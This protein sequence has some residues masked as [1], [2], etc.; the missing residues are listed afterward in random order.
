MQLKKLKW[1]LLV[2]GVLY[3]SV[4]LAVFIMRSAPT[5]PL[6][7]G[8][9]GTV[10][11]AGSFNMRQRARHTLSFVPFLTGAVCEIGPGRGIL[12]AE[13]Q[14]AGFHYWAIDMDK[15]ALAGITADRKFLCRIPPMPDLPEYPVAI[16]IESV[17]EHMKDS[18]EVSEVLFGCYE[19]LIDGG[20]VVVRVPEIRYVKWEFWDAATDHSYVT[21]KRRMATLI[22]ASGFSIIEQGYYLDQFTGPA[23]HAVY[24]IKNLWPWGLLHNLFYE[25]WQ[26]S[27]FSK[28]AEKAPAVYVVAMKGKQ[29]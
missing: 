20:V 5:D 25:P 13:A 1:S 12:A 15:A 27:S 22:R 7:E 21:S 2:C 28:I 4:P 26:E 10:T 19:K 16:V 23:A 14:K 24:R 11:S 18:Q 3:S 29:R 8:W 6:K 17:L 9:S